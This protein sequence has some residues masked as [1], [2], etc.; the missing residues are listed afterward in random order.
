M[1]CQA[2]NAEGRRKYRN[3]VRTGHLEAE[4][5]GKRM[6]ILTRLL[7]LSG[8]VLAASLH[9]QP[10][11][12]AAVQAESAEHK[13]AQQKLDEAIRLHAEVRE[14]NRPLQTEID[15]LERVISKATLPTPEFRR[16]LDRQRLLLEQS[17]P[18]LKKA[19]V[20]EKTIPVL[21]SRLIHADDCLAMYQNTID[22]KT[23]DLTT[24]ESDQIKACKSIDLYPPEK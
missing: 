3:V 24:R 7:V 19:A 15:E 21:K 8:L 9:A 5:Y 6:R 12:P 14:L 18:I 16:A 10:P 13:Y 11:V 20:I 23:S 2:G 17:I 4:C 22:K 1:G